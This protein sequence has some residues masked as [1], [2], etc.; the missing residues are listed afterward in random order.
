MSFDIFFQPCRFCGGTVDM[1]NPFTGQVQSVPFNEPLNATE[2]QAVRWVLDQ[3]NGHGPDEDGFYSVECADG[4]MADVFG[5]NLANGCMAALRGVTP[6]LCQFLC[7]LLKAGNWVMLPAMEGAMA[8]TTSP[9]C[10]KDISADFPRV[11]VCNSPKEISV[12]LIDGFRGWEK[13]RDQF[14][15]GDG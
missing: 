15:G 8:I 10:L 1:E 11:V 6:D 2:L 13:Y 12:L 7:D 5:N 14:V 9:S 4:G 3:A